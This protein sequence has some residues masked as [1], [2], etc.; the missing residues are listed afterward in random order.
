MCGII[1]YSGNG[2]TAENL[3][4]GLRKL[5]YRGYDSAGIATIQNGGIFTYKAI[6][7]VEMLASQLP[8]INSNCGI[9]HTRWATNGKVITENC[10]P[11]MS[12]H[13]KIAVVHNGIIENSSTLKAR[14]ESYGYEFLGQTDT[15]SI[16]NLIEYFYRGDMMS[17]LSIVTKML[18]GSYAIGVLCEDYPDSIFVAKYQ[19]PLAVGISANEAYIAS[20]INALPEHCDKFILDDNQIL[21]VNSKCKIT[22][23]A[24]QNGYYESVCRGEYQH[25]MLK[26][27]HEQPQVITNALCSAMPLV[28][29]INSV[30]IIA[31]GSSYNAGLC[32][33]QFF[34]RR[35]IACS[36]HYASEYRYSPFIYSN[37][38]T[39][40]VSQSG[41]T[42]DTI[43]AETIAHER[44]SS[45]LGI[46][47][48][49]GSA[50]A[51]ACTNVLYTNAGS[52][53][54]VAT[55]KGFTSQLISLYRLALSLVKQSDAMLGQLS[56][57]AE[58]TIKLIPTIKRISSVISS[59]PHI[60]FIGR[61]ADFGVAK[62][63]ALKLKEI[64]YL[65]AEAY[66]AGELKHGA[67]SLIDTDTP[68]II[69]STN[70]ELFDKTLLALNTVKSRGGNVIAITTDERTANESAYSLLL[71]DCDFELAPCL[72]VIALQLLA[73]YTAL[74]LKR[75]IDMPRNLAKSVT[76]E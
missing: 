32:A 23:K 60:Y 55:T 68:V 29:A 42:A 8:T 41:E 70:P 67:I 22:N 34:E 38:L 66:P 50:L 14:L 74:T 11:I 57:C 16:S 54:S 4:R 64:S 71:P 35:G 18:V 53:I 2:N 45:T 76:V 25:Y 73:Y 15:E 46:V 28:G 47:N 65:H 61:G 31:C 5:E 39:V 21:E 33:K 30:Q 69:I 49:R 12:Y 6:G 59:Q 37:A 19:S 1:G 7:K 58:Q 27:I 62:E 9:G 13:K 72:A 20:D 75:D 56:S 24:S 48:V 10:H 43:S 17:T 44:N 40:F 36:I 3:I 52:E 63:G 51:R 26:E